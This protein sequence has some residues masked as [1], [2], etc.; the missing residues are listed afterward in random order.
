MD[1]QNTL[2]AIIGK[3]TVRDCAAVVLCKHELFYQSA[4]AETL[5]TVHPSNPEHA[6]LVAAI[7]EVDAV[8]DV[9][10]KIA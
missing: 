9:G 1:K 3:T 10:D 5:K 2:E 8:T 6:R 4:D 7:L